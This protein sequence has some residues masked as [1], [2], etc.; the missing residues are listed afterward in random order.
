MPEIHLITLL[1]TPTGLPNLEMLGL[2]I[3]KRVKVKELDFG[4]V[5]FWEP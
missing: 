4:K 3:P 5:V 2:L 1:L